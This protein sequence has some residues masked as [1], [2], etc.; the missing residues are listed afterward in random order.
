MAMLIGGIGITLNKLPPTRRQPNIQGGNC[1]KLNRVKFF[2]V[3]ALAALILVASSELARAQVNHRFALARYNAQ[4]SF[5]N[6]FDGNGRLATDFGSGDDGIGAIAIDRNG[7]IVAAGWATIAGERQFALARYNTNGSLDNTFSGDGKLLTSFPDGG[8]AYALAI[9]SNGKIVV[10]GYARV[11]NR[12]QF[13]VARYLSD[14]RLDTTFH[15]DG[16]AFTNFSSSAHADAI[17]IDQNG[18][19]VVAGH[20]FDRGDGQ[21]ALARFNTNGSLDAT[22]SQDGKVITEFSGSNFASID[23]LS[24]DQ[25]GR[26]V[27]VGSADFG[28]F[29][30]FSDYHMVLARYLSDGRLDSSFSVDG[31]VITNLANS[32]S[33]FGYAVSIDQSGKI[34]VAG[35]AHYPSGYEMVVIRLNTDGRLDLTFNISGKV[36]IPYSVGDIFAG[37]VAIDASG[38]I[39]VVGRAYGTS[40]S[41]FALARLRSDGSLDPAFDGNGVLV[42]HVGSAGQEEYATAVAIDA[43]GRIVVGGVI[44]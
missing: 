13:A 3:V 25:S 15:F 2:S 41:R 18:K 14:G 21:F 8:A 29:E 44:W 31:K 12:D 26:I 20:C 7:K 10:A 19:I 6:T 32:S 33:E 40:G 28:D 34:V 5:D 17:A 9:D 1:M 23:D 4:G 37:D 27:A 38:H 36:R 43:S 24:I 42:S 39:V 35:A 30:V 22:F 11:G 16:K